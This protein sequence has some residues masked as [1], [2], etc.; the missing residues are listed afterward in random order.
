MNAGKLSE[1][2]SIRIGC[3]SQYLT[4]RLY[5]RLKSLPLIR[6][7]LREGL[8]CWPCDSDNIGST[9]NE[10]FMLVKNW[11]VYKMTIKG[12]WENFKILMSFPCFLPKPIWEF[13][14]NQSR[15]NQS[16]LTEVSRDFS[17]LFTRFIS[18]FYEEPWISQSWWVKN[19]LA[20]KNTGISLFP[21]SFPI[22][23]LF[24][25]F[26]VFVPGG[27]AQER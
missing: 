13:H 17:L 19:K 1:T 7:Y 18:T 23:F 10:A 20:L 8:L 3:D 4:Y 6:M 5:T 2:V 21:V 26:A 14:H 22:L 16:C 15:K 24:I 11:I 25:M 27:K 9:R 12:K